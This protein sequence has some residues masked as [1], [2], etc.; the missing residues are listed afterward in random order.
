MKLDVYERLLAVNAGFDQ[1]IR[2]IGALRKHPEFRPD[3]IARFIALSRETR[4]AVNSYLLGVLEGAETAE[5]GHRF[6]KRW[7]QQHRDERRR[8][9]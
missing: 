9:T 6:E 8:K 7:E 2:A 1:A 3:E 4:A 5:A